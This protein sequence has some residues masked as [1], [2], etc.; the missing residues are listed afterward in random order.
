MKR[1]ELRP[2]QDS[3][4]DVNETPAQL[5]RAVERAIRAGDYLALRDAAY[6]LC[7]L[8]HRSEG[9]LKITDEFFAEP[10]S[11]PDAAEGEVAQGFL[12]NLEWAP[13]PEGATIQYLCPRCPH[14]TVER[15]HTQFGSG[16]RV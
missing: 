1:E 16:V 2:K 3:A 7:I 5:A 14:C 4:A 15:S 8:K 11:A 6:K 13:L 9:E 12:A 10:D